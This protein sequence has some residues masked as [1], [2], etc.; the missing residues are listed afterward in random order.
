MRAFLAKQIAYFVYLWR[1]FKRSRRLRSI[2]IWV[3]LFHVVGGIFLGPI[4]FQISFALI[5]FGLRL[6]MMML[7]MIVQFVALFWF[8]SQTKTIVV[9]PGDP[10]AISFKDYW[11]QE[12]LIK[13]MRQWLQLLKER[14]Q[15]Q[16]MGGRP[17]SGILLSG[18]PGTGKTYLAKAMAGEGGVAFLGMESSS[19]RGM[20]WGMD[21]LK[22]ISFFSKARALAKEYGACIAYLD[23][24][25]SIG[26]SRGGVQGGG[27]MMGPMG[28]M[29]STGALTRLLYE[30]DGLG[31]VREWDI[32]LDIARKFLGLP[33]VDQGYVLIMGATNRPDVL[34]PALL[35]P[36]RFDR[37]VT[38]DLPDKAGRRAII[39]GYLGKISHEDGIDIE[40][41]VSDTAWA[42][43]AKIASAVLK[44]AV[45]LAM[46]DN[47]DQ[48]AQ[49]DI[50]M[51]M[52]E[53]AMGLQNPISD[54]EPAQ[55]RQIA[56]HE[57][58]HAI[59][60]YYLRPDERIVHLTITRRTNA[61][62]FMLPVAENDIYAMP[63]DLIV[64]D[65]LVS[66][67]GHVATE[68]VLGKYWTGAGGDLMAVR[69]RVLFLMSHGMFGSF[70]MDGAMGGKMQDAVDNFLS[71]CI[72]KVR[73]LL[74]LH[75]SEMDALITVLLERKDM[76][77]KEVVEII[78]KV[79]KEKENE[80][81][82]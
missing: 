77:G 48:V 70:P 15:F 80:Q 59:S 12:P 9:H 41:L 44:D 13:M 14:G 43:P 56:I 33:P 47:R 55:E 22:V 3:V 58:G 4:I 42:T 66:L 78:E 79:R 6:A 74:V 73:E 38:V 49:R 71:A 34:D 65:I 26:M 25:D 7:M 76:S 28:M 57:S 23:E 39:T 5:S 52:M 19:F 63:L 1:L 51:S 82:G 60:Q 16:K 10:K 81:E 2:A 20:F 37:H 24:I 72:D 40:A 30:M 45:R 27:Q 53:Q 54:L 75:R 36:G 31:E 35:R 62:G 68:V 21:T 17:I 50:E 64:A 32:C 8:M 46:F 18:P 11:G 29:G 61:L 67:A 69:S